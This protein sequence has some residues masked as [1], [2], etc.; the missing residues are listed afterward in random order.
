MLSIKLI[1][2]LLIQLKEIWIKR[3]LKSYYKKL[4]RTLKLYHVIKLSFVIKKLDVM[5][6]SGNL[7]K[8]Y[9]DKIDA[10]M[11][12]SGL[13]NLFLEP[14]F[15]KIPSSKTLLDPLCFLGE[16]MNYSSLQTFEALAAKTIAR[17]FEILTEFG[18]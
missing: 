1:S 6:L 14:L 16:T 4:K 18:E 9:G 3:M 2:S 12:T 8:R 17:L 15:Q 11:T 7:L 13:I 10:I 5:D